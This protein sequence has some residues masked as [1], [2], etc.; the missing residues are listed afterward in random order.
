[1][2]KNR[3]MGISRI[4]KTLIKKYSNDFTKDFEANRKVLSKLNL[5]TKLIKNKVAGNI[6]R[7]KIREEKKPFVIASILPKSPL[8]SRQRGRGR[9]RSRRQ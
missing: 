5:P 3:S 6:V 2:G 8:D 7:L 1:M 4:S 9:R